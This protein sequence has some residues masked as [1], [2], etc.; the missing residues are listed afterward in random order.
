MGKFLSFICILLFS[1][2]ALAQQDTLSLPRDSAY[3]VKL[4]PKEIV[5]FN[6][7]PKR[8][9][10]I[11]EKHPDKTFWKQR[12]AIGLDVSEVAF[13]N[14][15]AGGSNSISGL[16]NVEL[17]RVYERAN[18]RWNNELI[19][20]Y[21]IVKQKEQIIQKT[22]DNFEINSTIGYRGDTLSNW[23]Y[24]AKLNFQTQ[25]SN[26]YNYPDVSNEISTLMSPAYIF[27][28]IGSE[29][30]GNLEFLNLY[31]SPLTVKSTIVGDQD[32]ANAGSF[33][34]TP[35]IRDEEGNVIQK[36]ENTRT[37]V[38][39]L[40]TSEFNT[41][42]FDNIGLSN[43]L[44]FYTDYLNN[45]GNIDVN[46]ELNLNFRVNNYVL[47]KI[48]SH[49]KYDD[50]IKAKQENADGEQVEVGPKVQWKQQLGIGVIVE[51]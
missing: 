35:A 32:L 39:I 36:G 15:N 42:L 48:G 38:G 33:G 2:N 12:N 23:F 14:W 29:Y 51:L 40:L 20:R 11:R 13:V 22:D 30:G 9:K 24:S 25:F 16:L 5:F 4:A 41:K 8:S 46:W 18:I 44:K 49:L 7:L 26:G 34:V 45:F 21:G 10:K 19:A 27:V 17:K 1:L 43:K 28:G 37:E 47:A 31:A 3:A 6:I 50:D